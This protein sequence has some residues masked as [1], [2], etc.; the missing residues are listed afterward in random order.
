LKGFPLFSNNSGKPTTEQRYRHQNFGMQQVTIV[1]Q[2]AAM[3]KSWTETDKA[4]RPPTL[5]HN[6]DL[7]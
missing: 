6:L 3:S 4:P 7:G 1:Q 5:F 2:R